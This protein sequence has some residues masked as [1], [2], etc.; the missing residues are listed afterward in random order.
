MRRT[1]HEK[2]NYQSKSGN[3]TKML[4]HKYF[5][6]N[7]QKDKQTRYNRETKVVFKAELSHTEN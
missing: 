4:K 2:T 5:E 7:V 6:G 1:R 3:E